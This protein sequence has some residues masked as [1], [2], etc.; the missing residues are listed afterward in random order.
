M[1]GREVIADFG[2]APSG[3]TGDEPVLEVGE[4]AVEGVFEPVTFSVRPGEVVGLAGLVGAGR[5]EILEA[6]YGA[7]RRTSGTVSVR[8]RRCAPLHH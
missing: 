4:L 2:G 3:P 5:S 7:R 1:T 6:V 8:E